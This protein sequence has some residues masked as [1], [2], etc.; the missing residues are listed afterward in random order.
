MT[1]ACSCALLPLCVNISL[2]SFLFALTFL[3]LLSVGSISHVH[4][5]MNVP[6]GGLHMFT[7]LKFTKITSLCTPIL[8]DSHSSLMKLA[9]AGIVPIT[10]KRKLRL[11][12]EHLVSTPRSHS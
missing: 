3:S 5:S 11:R 9:M 7:A 8:L 10:Q 12:K 4:L 6:L 1:P 2:C